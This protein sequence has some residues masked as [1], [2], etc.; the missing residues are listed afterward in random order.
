[1]ATMQTMQT[2]LYYMCNQRSNNLISNYSV[3]III[4][5]VYKHHRIANWKDNSLEV[6]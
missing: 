1:M 5:F 2:I 4:N 6:N 3:T